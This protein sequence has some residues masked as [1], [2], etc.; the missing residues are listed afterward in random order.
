MNTLIGGTQV[1]EVAGLLQK[2]EWVVL[3]DAK[4]WGVD[5]RTIDLAFTVR[6]KLYLVLL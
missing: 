6:I 5:S 2:L 4:H 1:S 3:D